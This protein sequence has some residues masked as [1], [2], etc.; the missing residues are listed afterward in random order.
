MRHAHSGTRLI[1]GEGRGGRLGVFD[2]ARIF[3]DEGGVLIIPY[4]A[5]A[6]LEAQ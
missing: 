4:S 1:A 6:V 2:E 3:M 5:E